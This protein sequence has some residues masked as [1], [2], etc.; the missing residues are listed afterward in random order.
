MAERPAPVSVGFDEP[1]PATWAL[2]GVLVLVH[3]LTGYAWW[4]AG[5]THGFGAWLGGRGVRFRV[6]VG[7]QYRPLVASGQDWRLLTSVLLHGGA[8]HLAVNAV[9]LL[10]LGRLVEP[11]VGSRRFLAWFLLG[12]AAGS[13]ASQLAQVSRSDGASGGAFALLGAALVLGWRVRARLDDEDRRLLG[14]VLAAFLVLNVVLSFALPFIDAAGHLGG[15]AAGL[16]L[17]AFVRVDGVP[18]WRG[19]R[20]ASVAEW[21]LVGGYLAVCAWGWSSL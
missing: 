3:L 14:P 12:G 6:A 9:A 16:G 7:G 19:G 8:L 18:P 11:W 10:A 15:L 1:L 21:M 5:N 20:V 17:A 2:V 4:H 13:V